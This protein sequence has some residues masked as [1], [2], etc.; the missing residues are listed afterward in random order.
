MSSTQD[1]INAME[2]LARI[3]RGDPALLA[4]V[5]RVRERATVEAATMGRTADRTDLLS[6]LED[7]IRAEIAYVPDPAAYEYVRSPAFMLSVDPRG[8]CDDH[9]TLAKAAALELGFAAP[10]FVRIGKGSGPDPYS[11][12]LLAVA[13]E[14]IGIDGI[15]WVD[16]TVIRD[17][18]PHILR[19][20]PVT[21]FHR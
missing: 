20:N 10:M 1:T 15:A 18:L 3:D 7:Q 19:Q 11:H 9:A 2:R 14:E 13:G 6:A 21:F 12:V 8:D 4:F 5:E 17:Q 16:S